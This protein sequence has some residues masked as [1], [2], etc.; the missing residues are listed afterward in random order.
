MAEAD[1]RQVATG[2]ELKF[3]YEKSPVFRVIHVDG[4]YG[5]I[6]STTGFIHMAVFSERNPIPKL[7]VHSLENGRIGPEI[8][9]RRQGRDGVFREIE[10]DLVLSIPAARSMKAWLETQIKHAEDMQA[11]IR[12]E[13]E[14]ERKKDA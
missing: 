4:A 14:K 10:A 5:G 13:V 6:I 8:P 3:H 9:E 12:A 11:E 1:D 2:D 7:M